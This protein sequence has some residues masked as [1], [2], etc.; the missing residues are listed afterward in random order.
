M[1]SA[2]ASL[3]KDQT[4][5]ATVL[6]VC[7]DPQDGAVRYINAGHPA[8]LLIDGHGEVLDRL[9]RTALPLGVGSAADIG[10]ARLGTGES[11]LLFSDGLIESRGADGEELGEEQLQALLQQ[12]PDDQRLPQDLV[13][14]VLGAARQRATDW[15]NDDV[16][17]VAVQRS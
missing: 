1:A 10:H 16:T 12:V 14:W 3:F 8:G 13:A 15:G 17:L 4:W 7:I 2:L 9:E 11:I 6:V 5:Y